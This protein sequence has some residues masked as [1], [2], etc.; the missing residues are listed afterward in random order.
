MD[1]VNP[2]QATTLSLS[3][4]V[5]EMGMRLSPLRREITHTGSSALASSKRSQQL[6]LPQQASGSPGP[7]TQ[8]NGLEE[9]DSVPSREQAA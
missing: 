2:G 5:S 1:S 9:L 6:A 7:G 4:L 3:Y 8:R